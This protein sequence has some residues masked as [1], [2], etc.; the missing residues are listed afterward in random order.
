MTDKVHAVRQSCATAL[1]RAQGAVRLSVE[2]ARGATRLRDLYQRGAAKCLLPRHDGPGLTAVLLNTAGGLTGGDTL[3]AEAT[4]GPGAHLTLATQTAE[5]A[6]RSLRGQ[7]ATVTNRLHA[8]DGALLHW[9][10]QETIFFDGAALSR[11]LDVDL[12]GDARLLAVEAGILGRTAMGETVRDL[13]FSDRWRI[14]RNGRLVFADALRL[15]GDP[16][17]HLSGAATLGG[18]LAFATVLYAAP[19]AGLETS[20]VRG[21]VHPVGAASLVRPGILAARLVAPD[22]MTLR[23]HLMPTLEHL[24][25]APLPKTWSI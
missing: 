11:Q 24:R 7:M 20:A 22:R 2:R 16:S 4:A 13:R 12:H 19:D 6:Y 21:H 25:G 3:S 15:D 10:P 5:R 23:R 1:P 8:E 18:A 14:R 17:A 9:L